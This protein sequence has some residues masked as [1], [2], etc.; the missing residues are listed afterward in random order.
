MIQKQSKQIRQPESDHMTTI[1]DD[2][3]DPS[4]APWLKD[5]NLRKFVDYYSWHHDKQLGKTEGATVHLGTRHLDQKIYACKR[6]FKTTLVERAGGDLSKAQQRARME[7]HTAKTL[8][9]KHLIH[10][11]DAFETHTQIILIQEFMTGG[12]LYD[13]VE[14]MDGLPARHAARIVHQIL[15]ALDYLHSNHIIHR[16]IKLQ[17]IML[18]HPYTTSQPLICKIADLGLATTLVQNYPSRHS[19]V[20][21]T[22]YMAPEVTTSKPYDHTADLYS[23]GILTYTLIKGQFPVR[24]LWTSPGPHGIPHEAWDFIAAITCDPHHRLSTHEAIHHPWIR[25]NIVV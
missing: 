8:N 4:G 1:S 10:T 17:N 14:Q 20:G 15:M 22:I 23:L 21:T 5:G 11:Y 7:C 9:H 19:C 16:D 3:P 6:M 12:D 13:L 18:L 24:T 2:K 25:N